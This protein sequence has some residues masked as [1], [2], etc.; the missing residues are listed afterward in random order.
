MATAEAIVRPDVT[1]RTGV[2][3]RGVVVRGE[4]KRAEGLPREPVADSPACGG[5]DRCRMIAEAAY[6]RAESRGFEGGSDLDD[7]LAAEMDIDQFL[8]VVAPIDDA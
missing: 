8:G 6:Y 1:A 4:P 3:V 7:W 2:D 5:E